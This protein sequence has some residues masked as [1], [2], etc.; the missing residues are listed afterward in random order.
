MSD[1]PD[2]SAAKAYLGASAVA[3]TDT[4]ISEALAAE[5]A[6]QLAACRVPVDVDLNLDYSAD[7]VNALLR[8]VARNLAMRGVPLGVQPDEAGGIRLSS[9]DPEVR[10]LEAP[11]RRLVVA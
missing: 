5:S 4:Q 7:L 10:R 6:A 3:Y 11:Y 8:R 2:L 9:I 1:A